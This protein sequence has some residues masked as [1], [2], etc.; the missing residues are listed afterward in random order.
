M[1]CARC[2]H[3][4]R[5]GAKF[6]EECAAPLDRTCA[7]CGAPMSPTAKFCS[8]CA[9]PA[10]QPPPSIPQRFGAP[11]PRFV[12]PDAYTPKHLAERIL[13]SKAALEGERKQVTVLF[14]DLKGSMELLADRDPEEAR[15]LLDPVLE[16]M[17]EAV[18]RYEG[19][20][21]QVMGDGIM[22]LFGAPLAH[23]DHAVRACYAAL[24]MQESVKRYAADLQRSEGVPIA[25]RVGLNSGEVVVRAIGSDLRMDYSAIG[26]TTHLAARMEQTAMPGSILVTADTL[27]LAEGYVRVAPLG[28]TRIKGLEAPVEV[29]EVIGASPTRTRLQASAARGL[30]RFVGRD[31]ELDQIR[32]ALERARAG[33]GQVVAVMGEPGV[34]KSRLFHELIRSHRTHGWLVLQASSVSY[35]RATLYLPVIELLRVYFGIQDRDDARAIRERVT[36]KIL[37]LDEAFAEA[38]PPTLS[39]LEA[40]PEDSPFRALDA[41]ERRRRTLEA[42]KRLV[43]REARIQPLLLVFEDLH[44]IDAETQA[45]LD[46]LVE[47]LA[48][49]PL[50][51]LVNYRPEYRHGWGNKTC[52][53]QLRLDP[54]A[55]EDA[56]QLLEALVGADPGLASLK[57][58]LIERT[59]GNPFF[60]EESVRTMVETDVL[61]GERG[62][63]RLARHGPIVQMP[64]TVQAVLA[65][66]ID[67]LEP[68]DKTLLQMAAVIGKNVPLPL[69]R[70]TA[71]E[72]EDTLLSRLARLQAAEFL[73]EMSS[74][75][76]AEYTFKHALT[77][78]VGYTSLL[79]ERRRALHARVLEALES[80]TADG[81]Y[82]HVERLAHHALGAER[83]DRAAVY[84]YQAGEK[85][86]AYGAHASAAPFFEA[87]IDA[88]DRQGGPG[89]RTLKLDACLELWAVRMETAQFHAVGALADTAEAL[90]TSLGDGPRLAK[91]RGGRAQMLWAFPADTRALGAAIE[92][93]REASSLADPADL[94]TRSYAQVVA[95]AALRDLGDLRGSIQE[96]DRGT[97]LFEGVEMVPAVQGF[98][99]PIHSTLCSWRADGLVALGEFDRAMASGEEG[100]RVADEIGHPSIRAQA[101]SSLGLA[102]LMRGDVARSL[103][104]LE[105]GLGIAEEAGA[106]FGIL[107]NA[108]GLA[109]ARALLGDRGQAES[110]LERVREVGARL[111]RVTTKLTRYGGLVAATLLA[112]GR[113]EEARAEVDQ[114][115]A[116]V[117]AHAARGYEP[118]L[119]WLRAEALS[120][121]A[122][123][124]LGEALRSCEQALGLAQRLEMRPEIGHCHR[125][126]SRLLRRADDEA[127]ARNHLEAALALFRELGMPFWADRVQPEQARTQ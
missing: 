88:V 120:S 107:T 7:S 94:R 40:L 106:V 115:L 81:V 29:Y 110:H 64:A 59:E 6:C 14:A 102:H 58:L 87:A 82:E 62:A 72:P 69:L 71:R 24:R 33:H 126:M 47:G 67:R 13:T 9:H 32:R 117:A 84:L 78:E 52:Y 8:E 50:L 3:E 70:T 36:G 127:S 35:G 97:A 56:T 116:L 38:I 57:R 83:W 19:T 111:G 124:A 15:T 61:V 86:F 23:E 49:A 1:K 109:F 37:T 93:A 16:H 118:T 76:D 28:P 63:Y 92:H 68:G 21:N 2:Q 113:A 44:W 55:P 125:V 17:M 119:L 20:V 41:G 123:D 77:L 18:H 100:R 121:Q 73:Y 105:P 53:A 10:A 54:L 65:A 42:L 80:D 89:D 114:G 22:A 104:M 98:V 122:P 91:V 74:F 34:G 108:L 39:L 27:R 5:P 11:E 101:R 99:R 31:A 48:T 85:V 46:S 51:L 66:R 90:A 60:L 95:G 96:Y 4:H 79:Q 43:L 75:P 45:L 12:A 25:I 103:T 26:Q 112:L 30:T